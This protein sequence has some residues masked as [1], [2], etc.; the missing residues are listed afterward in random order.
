V[1]AYQDDGL[2]VA[3]TRW[4]PR[5][6]FCTRT[7]NYRDAPGRLYVVKFRRGDPTSAAASISEVVSHALLQALGIRTFEAAL[8]RVSRAM[9][10]RL[11]ADPAV[12]YPIVPGLHFGTRYRPDVIFVDPLR[13]APFSWELLADPAE[14]VSIWA[15]DSWLMN[16]D[17]AVYGNLVLEP[18]PEG[19]WHLLAADQSDCFLG[20]SALAD[21][22]CFERS[23]GHGAAAF[24]PLLERAFLK[25]GI[26]PLQA[27]VQRIQGMEELLTAAVVRVP[28]LWWQEARIEPQAVVDC[29]A[30]R[31]AQI[32]E[33]VQLERWE[34]LTHATE[35]GHLL[36]G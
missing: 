10:R 34:G 7:A 12:G 17:R 11:S 18:G 13:A 25:Q 26:A 14:L 35:G 23:A 4:E 29:L 2:L 9:A 1:T 27:I 32:D 6:V 5:R 21:G 31:A 15:A 19:Q 30:A 33:I 22:S 36:G 8:V 24:L 16:L 20:A 3:G 28:A